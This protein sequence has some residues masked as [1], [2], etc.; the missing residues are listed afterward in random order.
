MTRAAADI[1]YDCVLSIPELS[2][3]VDAIKRR[4]VLLPRSISELFR[5]VIMKRTKVIN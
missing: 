3:L 4:N 2:G 1:E 5:I